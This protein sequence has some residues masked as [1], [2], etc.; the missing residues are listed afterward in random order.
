MEVHRKRNSAG[1]PDLFGYEASG[2]RW[3]SAVEAGVPCARVIA[4]DRD[5]LELDRLELVRPD[6]A[7]AREFGRRLAITHDAGAAGFGAPPDGWTKP[8]YFGPAASPLPMSLTAHESWGSS[9]RSSDWS[10]PW[11]GRPT[12]Y[13]SR[14]DAARR[15]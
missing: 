6:A 14:R 7:A 9:T 5:T 1:V 11:R 4:W 15:R 8:G 10:P 12:T 13:P 3:L 2:L